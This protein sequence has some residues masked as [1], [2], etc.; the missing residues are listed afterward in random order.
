MPA[1]SIASLSLSFGLVSIPVKLYS[2][3]ESEAAVKFNFICQD[4]SRAK[5]QYISEKTGKPVERADLQKGYEF[6]KDRFVVFSAEELKAL[7]E[8]ASHV[9]DIVAFIPEKAVDPIY[10]DKTYFIAPDKRGGKPYNLLKQALL[11]SHQCALAKW[12]SKGKSHM[13]QIRPKEDGLVFQQLLF[14]DEVRSIKDLQIEEVDVSDAELKLALQIIDQATEDNYDPSQYE[15]EEKK[16][17]LKAIDEKIAGKKI[18]SPE[19][20][21]VASSGQVIDLM[22]ALRASL[23]KGGKTKAPATRAKTP[24]AEVPALATKERKGVKRAEKVEPAPT[25]VRARK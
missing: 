10:Y 8:G 21:E 16:R 19:Q 9:V 3:T 23:A 11:K 24:A 20:V 5:Q 7:E 14:A 12:A 25:R 13:V 17:I 15:D 22:D 6:D 18:V 1:R 2:A 4:G